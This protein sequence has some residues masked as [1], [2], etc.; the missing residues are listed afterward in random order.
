MRTENTVNHAAELLPDN[1]EILQE[2]ARFNEILGKH[3]HA[4]RALE[5]SWKVGPRGS[6]VAVKLARHYASQ[7]DSERSLAMLKSALER[8]PET[9]GHIWKWQNI[10]LELSRI[11]ERLYS[12][13]LFGAMHQTIRD[14]R[15][16]IFMHNTCFLLAGRRRRE[17]CFGNRSQCTAEFPSSNTKC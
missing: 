4:V 3:E 12:N 1:A 10:F 9:I 5:R 11:A 7:R 15:P 16:D 17:S 2:V 14:L 8:T 13:T 6:S